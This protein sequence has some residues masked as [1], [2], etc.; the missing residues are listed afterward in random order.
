MFQ[1]LGKILI[2]MGLFLIVGGFLFL[3]GGK[4]GIGHL[5]GDFV[6]KRGNFSFY[7]PL[8]TCIILSLI[9]TAILWLIRK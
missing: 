6:F 7:F 3:I 9:F 4:L 2:Y 8:M 5:P 1:W